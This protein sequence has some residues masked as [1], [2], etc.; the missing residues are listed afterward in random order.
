M[1]QRSLVVKKGDKVPENAAGILSR[2]GVTPMKIGINLIAALE[3]GEIY[4]KDALDFDEEAFINNMKQ[5][6]ADSLALALETSIINSETIK[7]LLSKAFREV[8]H[9]AIEQEIL[10]SETAGEILSKAES[11]AQALNQ[12]VNAQ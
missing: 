12:K 11:Q 10:G 1:W 7:L 2:L 5:A 8:K 4:T 6:Y 9:L 3:K